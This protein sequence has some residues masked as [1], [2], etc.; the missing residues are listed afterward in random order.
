[1]S[2]APSFSSFPDLSPQ[3]SQEQSKGKIKKR[4][5]SRSSSRDRERRKDRGKDKH[6]TRKREKDRGKRHREHKTHDERQEAY[7]VRKD[8]RD[9]SLRYFYSDRRGDPLNITY[10]RIHSG[11][12]PKYNVYH[13]GRKVLGLD[14][15]WVAHR[16]GH[17]VEVFLRGPRKAPALTDARSRALLAR[18]PTQHITPNPEKYA[19]VDGVITVPRRQRATAVPEDTYRAITADDRARNESD[20][21]EDED[22]E[23]S[24]EEEADDGRPV[25]SYHQE[26]LAELNRRVTAEPTNEHA[27]LDLLRESLVDVPPDSKNATTARA[28]ITT[29]ILGRALTFNP[30]AL[31]LRREYVKAG[32]EIWHESRVR[33]EWEAALKVGDA[34][35]WMEWLEWRIGQAKD[36][37]SGIVEDA[38]RVLAST[39]D[40]MLRV[41]VL[42]RMAELF[43]S[44]GY[45]ERAMALFQAQAEWVLRLPPILRDHP[46]TH[47]LDE[48]EEFWDSEHARIGE[49]NSAGWA[50][51]VAAGKPALTSQPT[52]T[53]SS[54][55]PRPPTADPHTRWAQSETLADTFACL[56]TRTFDENADAD[57]YSTIV[58]SD[59]RPLLSPLRDP[60]A[61]D[62]LRTAW[63]ALLGLWVP[64]N[65]VGEWDDRWA[66]AHL[67][68]ADY[69][70]R[71]FERYTVQAGVGADAVAGTLVGRELVYG[72]VF[73]P[74]KGWARGV[75]RPMEGKGKARAM[76]WRPED[77]EDVRAE[78]VR[79]VFAQMRRAGGDEEWDA[80]ALAFEA[81]LRN[82]KAATK[83]SRSFL[84]SARDSLPHWCMHAQLERL[85]GRL[86][87]ARKVYNTVLVASRPSDGE[88]GAA[89][90]WS[91]WA[92]MEWLDGKPD[93][94]LSI[95]MKAA[96]V[97]GQGGIAALRARRGLDDLIRAALRWKDREAWVKLRA[98]FELL[99]TQAL[100]PALTV[101]DS[102]MPDS[103]V[104]R[105]SM[106]VSALLLAY[107]HSIVLR[108]PTPPALLRER[109]R[110]ALDAYPSNS[111]VL[112]MVLE[113]EKGQAIAGYLRDI[114][115][116]GQHAKDVTRRAMDVWAGG[117][118]GR[119]QLEA[120]RTRT[121]LAMAVERS[122]TKG[123][124]VLWRLYIELEVRSGDFQSAK[125]L[126]YRAVRECPFAKGLYV[127]AFDAL[128]PAF[129]VR[130]LAELGDLMAER[131]IR[132]RR[133]VD[134]IEAGAA[135]ESSGDESGTD[136]GD[137]ELEQQASEYRRLMP[138]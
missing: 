101:F 57:P 83:L 11:D 48:L 100:P 78:V 27:W 13:R 109:A 71:I 93:G 136:G 61:V 15:A 107:R 73:G 46:F 23:E 121:G 138:Y 116:E 94:A 115:G 130:E 52:A 18:P 62:V 41:R 40:D 79:A 1:M 65:G 117:W 29:A 63:L 85:R 14:S 135:E 10:G 108:T 43:K 80:L 68:R 129:S 102:H 42:W 19:E 82:W 105:E 132:M 17:G 118:N 122:R 111:V 84:A 96:G 50:S 49:P 44:A 76:L 112:A 53:A 2:A 126:L 34:D 30:R 51:W 33:A 64:S 120:E 9:A 106:T 22:E 54:A 81:A 35:M 123:S 25:L 90:L 56:P 134:E 66:R 110:A 91:D 114:R 104:A 77:V 119:W 6:D 92:E 24:S 60:A 88:P 69:V 39:E 12:I 98:L 59:V 124:A 7:D 67:A 87:E 95:V 28:E 26:K 4:Q 125:R 127:L 58:F 70:R 3:T 74:V 72:D 20:S 47:Q 31:T 133:G 113:A 8:E 21:S 32:E 97:E 99:S 36:A 38:G 128:R 89:Q 16:T 137:E 131:D 103:D 86:D 75:V 37:L 55:L 45:V 5:R